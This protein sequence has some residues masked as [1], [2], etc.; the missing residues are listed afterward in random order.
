MYILPTVLV[1]VLRGTRRSI[2]V[3]SAVL[4]SWDD[5]AFP[6]LH[7]FV[8]Y[9]RN[10]RHVHI[11]RRIRATASA[12]MC[13]LL[14]AGFHRSGRKARHRHA[15]VAEFLRQRLAEVQHERF[16][17]VINRRE[18]TGQKCGYASDVQHFSTP[19]LDLWQEEFSQVRQRDDIDLD[20]LGFV[21]PVGPQERSTATKSG[22]VYQHIDDDAGFLQLLQQ[23]NRRRRMG[24][25]LR[26]DSHFNAVLRLQLFANLLQRRSIARDQ[27]QPIVIGSEQPGQFQPNAAGRTRDQG[28]LNGR[29]QGARAHT[30]LI[31]DSLASLH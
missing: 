20:H 6:L 15:A 24:K 7:P 16:A 10:V 2:S 5:D 19:R 9:A 31:S 26:R 30:S 22:V 8:T 13:A 27:H 14:E 25:V 18:W 21:M 17:G 23:L 28:S 1:T 4:P 3:S 29:R 12:G 11:K